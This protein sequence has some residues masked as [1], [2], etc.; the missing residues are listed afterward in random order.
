MKDIK[1]YNKQ[2][3]NMENLKQIRVYGIVCGIF[4]I[5]FFISCNNVKNS[6][7]LIEVSSSGCFGTCPILDL[8]FDKGKIYYNLIFHNNEKGI[9]VYNPKSNEQ[10]KIESLLN[11]IEFNYLKNEYTSFREDMPAFN[12]FFKTN[13][14]SKRIYFYAD[15]APKELEDLVYYLIYLS[16]NDLTKFDSSFSISTR[17]GMEVI[18]LDPPPMGNIPDYDSKH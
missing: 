8:K 1:Y 9:F 5:N 18:K 17:M 16:E 15:D 10:K 13:T 11:L 6:M 14:L 3:T 2:I 7:P 4:F 12:V